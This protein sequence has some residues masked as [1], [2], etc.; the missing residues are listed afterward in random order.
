L[1][2]YCSYLCMRIIVTGA[3]GSLGAALTRY[4]SKR[5]HEVTGIGSSSN[6]PKELLKH[7]EYRSIDIRNPFDLPA[8]DLCIHTSSLNDPSKTLEELIPIN[9][10]GTRNL[11]RAASHIED[12]IHFSCSSV[13]LPQEDP[14]KEELAGNQ[15]N[16]LLSPLGKSKLMAEDVIR[17]EF[18][19]NSCII[20]R[21][22]SLYGV[23]DSSFLP[24]FL[25]VIEREKPLNIPLQPVQVSMTNFDNINH[26]VLCAMESIIP[27]IRVYNV[28]DP[29]PYA[30][31]EAFDKFYSILSNKPNNVVR[32]SS[33]NWFKDF[34]VG[35]YENPANGMQNN[36]VLDTSRVS[37]EM[38]YESI[39][40]LNSRISHIKTWVA[41]LGGAKALKLSKSE[42]SWAV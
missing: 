27:G 23:G 35:G 6:P 9:V 12:L 5:G 20:L 21:P 17:K 37:L 42:L 10:E 30:V 4:L 18:K 7:A 39:T 38:N 11:V 29:R 22:S 40:D 31:N 28:S 8:A 1:S 15:D 25:E 14:I 13:Y 33:E 3:T 32:M 34:L 2:F 26:V 41:S 36:L 19:G 16:E 24:S